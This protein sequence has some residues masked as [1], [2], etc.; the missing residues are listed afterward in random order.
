MSDLL[1]ATCTCLAVW[2]GVTSPPPCAFDAVQDMK[3]LERRAVTRDRA[4]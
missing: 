2:R 1:R 3:D 4:R